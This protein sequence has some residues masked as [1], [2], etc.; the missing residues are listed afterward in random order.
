MGRRYE[1][2][3]K[4][5]R[6]QTGPRVR[7]VGLVHVKP[8]QFRSNLGLVSI[9]Q[10][11][12]AR[13]ITGS[14]RSTPVNRMESLTGLQSMEDRQTGRVLQ[15]AEKFKR[16]TGHPMHERING[17]GKSRLKRTNFVALANGEISKQEVLANPAAV[18]LTANVPTPP[19]K[20]TEL[21]ELIC[22]IPGIVDKQLQT[23]AERKNIA[24]KYITDNFLRAQWAHEY[25]D[26]SAKKATTNGGGGVYIKLIHKVHTI[27]VVTGKYC[28]NYKAEAASLVHAAKALREHISDARDK[29]GDLHRR[30][31]CDDS[32]KESSLNRPG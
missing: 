16:L 25:T 20:K 5:V 23:S 3:E 11:S 14:L 24:V 15:Q 21:P 17:D 7:H 9:V 18:S 12:A 28:N 22:D 10:N 6:R 8:N 31:I 19:W 32:P 4:T 13:I 29:G 2:S 1:R 30:A 27:A 26:G